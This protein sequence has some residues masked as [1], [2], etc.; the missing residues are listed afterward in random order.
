MGIG[1]ATQAYSLDVMMRIAATIYAMSLRIL[2]DCFE[3]RR[4]LTLFVVLLV[5]RVVRVVLERPIGPTLLN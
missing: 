4:C 1:R 5:V 3:I 2:V